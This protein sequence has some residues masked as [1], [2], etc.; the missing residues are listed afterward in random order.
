M[1]FTLTHTCFG[2]SNVNPI[3]QFTHTR[4][5]DGA[6]E[7][8]GTLKTVVRVK[9]LHYHQLYL[10]RPD[11]IAFIGVAVDTSVL[12]YDD[13]SRLIFL[14]AHREASALAT[15]GIGSISFFSRYFLG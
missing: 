1:D 12:I 5:S 14:P 3:G 10:N 11:P 15:G 13:F 6:P 9:I 8:D 4:C 7:A 2:R